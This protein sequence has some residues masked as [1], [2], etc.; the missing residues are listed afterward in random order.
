MAQHGI[1][2]GS[3]DHHGGDEAEHGLDGWFHIVTLIITIVG[4]YLL[5]AH[6]PRGR[7]LPDGRSFTGQILF[8]WGAFNLV[9]GLIDHY[10]LEIHDVRDLPAHVPIY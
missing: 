4:G 8:G 5:L 9:E 1:S 7:Q 2:Q 10:L 3:A 6:A